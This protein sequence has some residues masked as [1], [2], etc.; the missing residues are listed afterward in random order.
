MAALTFSI[1]SPPSTGG[2]EVTAWGY[3]S[4]GQ[5]TV[6]SGLSNVVAIAAGGWHSLALKADGAV[7]GWGRNDSGQTNVPGGLSNVVAIAAGYAHSLALAGLPPD[8]AKPQLV[9]PAF[10]IGTVEPLSKLPLC[11]DG[12]AG[13]DRLEA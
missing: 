10:L 12:Q 9:E 2:A 8:L 11:G 7:L 13:G 1:L 5:T 4:S 6:P 3:N